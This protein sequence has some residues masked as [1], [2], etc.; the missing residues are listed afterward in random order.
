MKLSDLSGTVNEVDH[1][2]KP[3]DRAFQNRQPTKAWR[4]M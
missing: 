3:M 1:P 4:R 2:R